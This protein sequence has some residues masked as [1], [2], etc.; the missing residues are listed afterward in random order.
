MPSYE[1]GRAALRQLIAWTTDHSEEGRGEA[2]TRF[3]LIDRLLREVLQWYPEEIHVE[4]REGNGI[5]DYELGLDAKTLLIEA[6]KEE[7]SFELPEGFDQSTMALPELSSLDTSIGSAIDQALGYCFERGIPFAVVA[8]GPQWIGFLASRNDGTPPRSGRA[9]VFASL[10][11]ME[12]R[13]ID[14]WNF[15]SRDG[16]NARR[17]AIAL[18]R[19]PVRTPPEKLSKRLL[20]YPGY[21]NR[22]PEAAELQVLGGM[23]LE[24]LMRQS[25]VERDF[26]VDCYTSSGSLS[27]YALVSRE[28]LEARYSLFFEREAEV[29]TQPAR[30]KKG[31][32]GDLLAD[33]AA[34]AL[35]QRPI[36]LVGDVGVGKTIFIRHFINIDGADVLKSAIVLY[37]DFGTQ[38]ALA[39]DLQHYILAEFVRQLRENFGVDVYDNS[40]V[41]NVY[42]AELQAFRRGTSG[43]LAESN[44]A[45]FQEKEIA[46]LDGLV[47]D[48]DEHL[49]RSL[50][51][52]LKGS[53][54][55]T[56]VFLDNIDQR[57]TAFQ[58]EVFLAAQSM[59]GG[60]PCTCFVALRPETFHRS[61]NEGSLTGYQPRVFTIAPPRVD[62]VIQRRI[63]FARRQLTDTGR[64]SVFPPNVSLDSERLNKYMGVLE[65]AFHDS[66]DIVEFVDNMSGGNVRRALDFVVSFVGS[67]HVDSRK[68]FD[69]LDQGGKYV[70]PMHEFVRAVTFGEHTHYDPADSPIGN[71]FDISIPDG[72]EHF[73]QGLLLGLADRVGRDEQVEGY[74]SASAFF[75]FG[76]GLGFL[77]AQIEASLFRARSKRMLDVFPR[78]SMEDWGVD[79]I[80]PTHYRITPIGAYTL[81]RLMGMF[82]YVDAMVVDTPIVDPAITELIH[83]VHHIDERISRLQAFHEYLDE[84]WLEVGRD[85][86]PLD[87]PGISRQLKDSTAK[88]EEGARRMRSR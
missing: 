68:I 52:L 79:P 38:P 18:Q 54:R 15:F 77:P 14:Y 84:R 33:V 73:L 36:I 28:I 50:E 6:K 59:A 16:V 64:L 86:L 61:R 74:V 27:Q 57:P 62:R 35:A 53:Q 88:V 1:E 30:S 43:P 58:E 51:I 13:F 26:L 32:S 7:I 81:K 19:A 46:H 8:N 44:P 67:G 82:T 3:H 56:V 49:K 12:E 21:K 23:F 70:L 22:N 78:F 9:I 55:Q 5:S 63:K 65:Q 11:A 80:S 76:Q 47:S 34:A 25:E 39:T 41:R 85:D 20:D 24:D 29:S 2:S 10:D 83:D 37:V 87:W 42:Q 4:R 66:D 75:E 69:I 48:L 45:L 17:L 72:R 71:V 31:V 40:F 60:W